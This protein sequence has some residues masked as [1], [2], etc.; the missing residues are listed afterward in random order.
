MKNAEIKGFYKELYAEMTEILRPHG[1]RRR[2]DRFRRLSPDGIISEIEI[3]R[4]ENSA[5]GFYHFTINL[6]LTLLDL[7][8]YHDF[9]QEVFPMIWCHLGEDRDEWPNI[10][11]WYVLEYFIH[12]HLQAQIVDGRFP[13]RHKEEGGDWQTTW[14]PVPDPDEIKA[15]VYGLLRHVAVPFLLAVSTKEEYLQLLKR[16]RT[17]EGFSVQRDPDTA[18]LYAKVYGPEFLPLLSE[19]IRAY[20]EILASECS[21]DWTGYDEIYQQGQEQRIAMLEENIALLKEIETELDQAIQID[22]I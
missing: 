20:E 4:Q 15:E 10:Q 13:F 7:S 17:E 2:G 18:R 14:V 19:D 9:W 16:A 8:V 22:Q 1:F 6:G 21:E 12:P 5:A 11:K 3:Q